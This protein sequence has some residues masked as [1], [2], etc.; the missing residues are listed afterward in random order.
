MARFLKN[1]V[2]EGLEL[3][4]VILPLLSL[5]VVFGMLYC[6]IQLHGL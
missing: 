6:F 4:D 3:E 1:K 2:N 5:L